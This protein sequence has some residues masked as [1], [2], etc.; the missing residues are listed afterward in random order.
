MPFKEG[1]PKYGG[2]RKGTRNKSSLFGMEQAQRLVQDEKY[3]KELQWRLTNGDAPAALHAFFWMMAYGRPFDPNRR[4]PDKPRRRKGRKKRR[5]D[6][7][8]ELRKKRRKNRDE[9]RAKRGPK[10]DRPLNDDG[11]DE[12]STRDQ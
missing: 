9:P 2:R 4:A 1:H 3:L 7:D 10:E 12:G 11:G 5:K 8:K 6:R